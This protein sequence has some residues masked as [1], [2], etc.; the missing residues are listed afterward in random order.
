MQFAKRLE[1]IPPYLFAAINRK[2]EELLAQG[3]DLINLG[4]GDPDLPTLTPV[5][6]AMHAALEDP[7]THNYPPHLPF[8]NRHLQFRFK[9]NHPESNHRPSCSKDSDYFIR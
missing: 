5:L 8:L 2:R 4:V 9:F 3:I 1:K 6:Q 7:Q